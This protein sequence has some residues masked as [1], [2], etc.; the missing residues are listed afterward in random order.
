MNY[1]KNEL[2]IIT[3]K[4][5]ENNITITEIDANLLGNGKYEIYTYRGNFDYRNNNEY[6]YM[7][8]NEDALLVLAWSKYPEPFKDIELNEIE[9]VAKELE[10][11]YRGMFKKLI[12]KI[13]IKYK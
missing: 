7:G 1:Q 9:T 4:F 12:S 5:K 6:F 8:L 13:E 11:E 3:N 10:N 2:D